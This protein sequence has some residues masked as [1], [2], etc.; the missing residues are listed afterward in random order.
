MLDFR[1]DTF[2]CVCDYMNYTKA[3]AALNLTQP[4]V[5]HH[6]H[7]LENT[8]G[9][10]LFEFSG[11]K[12]KLTPSG[13]LFHQA[14]MQMRYDEA[15]LKRK[16][17]IT[18][19]PPQTLIF[20]ATLTIGEFALPHALIEYIQKHKQVNFQMRILNTNELLDQLDK[21][22]IDFALIEGPFIQSHYQHLIYDSVP[23]IAVC[24]PNYAFQS[25]PTKMMDL[26]NEPLILREKGS[27]SREIFEHF[28][29]S[30]NLALEDF[31]HQLE[32]NH[33]G[34]IKKLAMSGC[35]ITFLYQTAVQEELNQGRLIK[36]P[37]E[38]LHI[39]HDFTFIWR[40]N[41]IFST[42]YEDL[43]EELKRL[44]HE[45]NQSK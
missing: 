4:A 21:A 1:I 27:G 19:T 2:L 5:S 23:Y 9:V 7:Y 26:K 29:Q 30:Q 24:S 15:D 13:K 11:K 34:V 6:I 31:P 37:I 17:M 35:G 43:F 44:H 25:F 20:G 28:L 45:Y 8:Y 32:I 18:N 40:K 22:E 10:K 14:A 41:S 39:V 16:L 38:S 3:A 42:Y 33:I 36:L 12:M